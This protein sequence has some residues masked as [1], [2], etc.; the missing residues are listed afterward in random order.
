MVDAESKTKKGRIRYCYPRSEVYHRWIHDAEYVYSSNGGLISGKHNYLK[1]RDIGKYSTDENIKNNW[2]AH[3]YSIIA[4]ID[5]DKKR[6]CISTK[7][8]QWYKELLLAVPDYYEIF[9]CEGDISTPNILSFTDK[10]KEILCKEHLKYS[11]KQYVKNFLYEF[12]NVLN[13]KFVLHTNIEDTT[14]NIKSRFI[15]NYNVIKDFVKKYKVKHYSW[16]NECLQEKFT[17]NN[18]HPYSWSSLTITL[19]TIK[20]VIT[21]TVFTKKEKEYFRKRYF[22]TKYCYG[23]GINFKE[24]ESNWNKEVEYDD[25][26]KFF[27]KK[28]IY[29]LDDYKNDKCI[30][31]NDYIVRAIEIEENY[32]KAKIERCKA[33]ANDNYNKALEIANGHLSQEELINNWRENKCN[34]N[35][36]IPFQNY[37]VICRSH[38]KQIRWFTDYLYNRNNFHNTQLKL[39]DDHI[40][41]SRN[42]CVPLNDAIRV[43]KIL[44]HSMSNHTTDEDI[45]LSFNNI[46]VGIY[47][48]IKIQ[49]TEKYTDTNEKLGYKRWLIK[50][51][52]HN[53][54]LDD[55][56]NFIKYYHL[57][58]K[59][60]N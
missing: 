57:E 23:R 39:N 56:Y 13:G 42:A 59:F 28:D 47:P 31:W 15:D 52:C 58:D 51:G 8:N 36:R 54:W 45:T 5:R 17:F 53:L 49:Y 4:V 18:Y 34:V 3:K 29:W 37:R 7:F 38:S 35:N 21:D 19:P 33:K 30:T 6:I 43:F 20:Q 44:H 41:T 14:R 9:W 22:Y 40:I 60:L 55:I 46:K 25:I 1:Y 10:D 26:K 48:L 27:K 16:Y 24:V 2:I 11:I 50:I 12:Y 32:I